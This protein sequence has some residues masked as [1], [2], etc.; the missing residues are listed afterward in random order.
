MTCIFTQG[1]REGGYPSSEKSKI[2]KVRVSVTTVNDS[3]PNL[4][5][6]SLSFYIESRIRTG[7]PVGRGPYENPLLDVGGSL[8]LLFSFG[9]V[10][11]TRHLSGH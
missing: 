1:V 10:R 5:P 3:S 6:E 4:F 8:S 9:V 2:P 7:G 11:S